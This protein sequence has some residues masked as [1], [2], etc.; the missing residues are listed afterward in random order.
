MDEKIAFRF[1][2]KAGR[3]RGE[4]GG[5]EVAFAEVDAIA[6]ESILIKHTEVSTSH[7]GRGYGSALMR[8]MLDHARA[9]GKTVIPIC[10]F[11]ARYI[12]DHGEYADLVKESFRSAMPR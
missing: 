8:F 7:G 1:D 9:E 4:L 2:E 12:S 6:G 10:P 3:F 11:A 5:E